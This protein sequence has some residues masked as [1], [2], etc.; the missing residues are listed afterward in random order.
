MRQLWADSVPVK[1]ADSGL[2]NIVPFRTIGQGQN[3]GY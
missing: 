1:P 2:G 3:K